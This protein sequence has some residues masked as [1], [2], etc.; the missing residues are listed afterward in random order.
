MVALYR[1]RCSILT[2]QLLYK[3]VA[4]GISQDFEKLRVLE[5]QSFPI[6]SQQHS[7]VKKKYGDTKP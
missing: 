3:I 1:A 2:I 4:S 7:V 5:E 6:I